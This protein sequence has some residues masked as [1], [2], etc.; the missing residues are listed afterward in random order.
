MRRVVITGVGPITSIGIGK[1]TFWAAIKEKRSGIGRVS[2]FDPSV[3][4]A[5][6][7]A[8]VLDWKPDEYFSAH[9]L[10]RL[11]RY[12]QFAVASVKL[13]LADSGLEYSADNPQER[14]GVSFV[15]ALGGVSNAEVNTKPSSTVDQD[16]S[17]RCSH[18]RSSGDRHIVMSQSSLGCVESARQTPA[19]VPVGTLRSAKPSDISEKTGLM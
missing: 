10:K 11:D 16:R 6:S 7:S 4:K 19:A 9:R 17:T 5:T 3:F 1:E 13:A 2:R 14:S 15:T 18:C 8:E 12:A